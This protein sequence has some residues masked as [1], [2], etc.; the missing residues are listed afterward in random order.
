MGTAGIHHVS[1]IVGD[2]QR[3]LD[4]YAG[5]LGLRLVKLTVNYDDPGTYHFYYG[6]EEGSPGSLITCF[7]WGREGQAGRIGIG[8]VAVTGLSIERSAIAYWIGRLIA[9]G[10]KYTGPAERFDDLVLAFQDP[11][12]NQLELIGHAGAEERAGWNGGPVPGASSVRGIHS[13]TL[14][15]SSLDPT[16]GLLTELLGL[17]GTRSDESRYR[18]EAGGSAGSVVDVRA[19]GGFWSGAMGVG[20]VHHVAFRIPTAESQVGVRAAVLGAGLAVTPVLDR[21]YFQSIYF[22]EPGG[23]LFESATDGPGFGIDEPIGQLGSELKLP[24]WLEAERAGLERR[25]PPIHVP[26][27]IDSD[28]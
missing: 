14:L 3:N 16:A 26:G 11:D 19:S 18:F 25:L 13:V 5:V 1:S 9:R 17:R 2:P 20:T 24:P 6:D 7:P 28:R 8:Q 21:Q 12:G 27:S 10:V 23:V 4:F 15:E 22:R